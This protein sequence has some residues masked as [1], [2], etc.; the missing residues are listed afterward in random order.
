MIK[1]IYFERVYLAY[2]FIVGSVYLLWIYLM[3][4]NDC[5]CSKHYLEKIVHIYWYVI[6]ILDILLFFNIASISNFYLIL[7]G[8]LIGLGNI[9]MTYQYIKYLDDIECKCSDM[10][11]KNL[12]I[13]IYIIT[14]VMIML[15]FLILLILYLSNRK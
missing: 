15:W 1:Q 2:N 5:K 4:Y 3:M 10:L 12:V 14:V 11:L 9:Y 7:I 13:I 6:F 8:N